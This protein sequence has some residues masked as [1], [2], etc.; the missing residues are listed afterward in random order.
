MKIAFFGTPRFAQIILEKLI[1]SPYKPQIIVTAPDTKVGRGRKLVVSQ[2]KQTALKN[3]LQV[4]APANLSGVKGQ[5]SDVDLAVLAA[6]GKII[7]KDILAI[8]KYGFI[9][10]HPSLLPKF[11]GPSPIQSAITAAE[12]KTGVTIIK[13]DKEVDHGPILA[14]EEIGIE[15]DDTHASLIEKLGK[16]GAELLIKTLPEYLEGR[17]K[18]KPQDH[19]KA[20]FTKRI[21]KTDGQIDPKN[22]PD[23]VIFDRMVR[24]FYPWPGVW[25]KVKVKSGKVIIIKFL[26]EN[27]IQPEG[28]RAMTIAEFKNG[29]PQAYE[30]ISHLYKS[31]A[32]S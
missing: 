4:F 32:Q 20:T 14:Q 16:L 17:L 22:P 25:L 12:E 26:P 10:V 1:N 21:T 5:I 18:P 6:F 30:Q 3:H 15:G 7:S 28:K 19:Q 9:N 27:L 2:V 11:R 29:Y 13:L 8:F 23:P 24:A 31:Q